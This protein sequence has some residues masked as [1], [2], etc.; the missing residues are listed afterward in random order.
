MRCPVLCVGPAQR[1]RLEEIRNNLTDWITET[2]REG[3]LGEAEGLRVS[4]AAADDK[5]VQLDQRSRRAIT[6][7][8]GIPAFGE[9]AGRT[10]TVTVTPTRSRDVADKSPDRGARR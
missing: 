8:L 9:I 3:W 4:L 2:E 5:L 6:F 1:P 7:N 10:A